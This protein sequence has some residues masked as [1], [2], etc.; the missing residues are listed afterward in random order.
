MDLTLLDLAE[1]DPFGMDVAFISDDNI[2]RHRHLP[3]WLGC[4][5]ARDALPIT[6][7]WSPPAGQRPVA[8]IRRQLNFSSGFRANGPEWPFFPV[9]SANELS[10]P[11]G[12]GNAPS[13]IEPSLRGHSMPSTAPARQ[14]RFARTVE[15]ALGCKG[16]VQ[17]ASAVLWP[18]FGDIA[19]FPP[20]RD[21]TQAL[22]RIPKFSSPSK[23]FLKSASR[24]E[25]SHH[26]SNGGGAPWPGR[27]CQT[28]PLP[29]PVRAGSRLRIRLR[30][31]LAQFTGQLREEALH[32][33]EDEEGVRGPTSS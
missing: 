19:L 7:G 10:M 23:P 22:Q 29:F 24:K 3:G 26:L 31:H 1:L 33:R 28:G 25:S 5:L 9:K 14:S 30:C 2:C 17:A 4:A 12:L 6:V 13:A 27:E 20:G 32:R 15:W 11:V 16:E 21:P 18:Q 8:G